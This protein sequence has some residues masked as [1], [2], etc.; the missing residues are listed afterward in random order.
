MERSEF[1]SGKS[2]AGRSEGSDQ[3][4]PIGIPIMVIGYKYTFKKILGFI[5]TEGD[6]S[7]EPGDPY[8][9]RF[10]DMYCNVSVCPVVRPHFLGRCFNAC[11]EIDNHN[12]MRQ[13][14]LALDKY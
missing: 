5:S 7:T 1:S 6:G 2:R 13:S 11:N 3:T 9:S 12:R 14:D 4:A 8:L 10:P